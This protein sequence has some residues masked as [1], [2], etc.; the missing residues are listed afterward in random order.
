M[1][2]DETDTECTTTL[3]LLAVDMVQKANSGH[4]GMPLGA[5]DIAHVLWTRYLRINP[6]NPRWFN[7]DRFVLSAGHGS[8]LLYALLHLSGFPLSVE[9]L[10]TFRQ[11]G[12]KCP[13]HP[14]YDP[15]LGLGIE[16][17]TGPLGQGLANAVGL[18][19]AE[20]ILAAKLNKP[21]FDVV[22]HMTYVI[23][24]DG[25]LMEGVSHEAASLAGHLGL[26]RLIVLYD[27]NNVSIDGTLDI[28]LS[29]DALGRFAAYGWD[30]QRCD[31]HNLDA[32]DSAIARARSV[33]NKPHLIAC[34]TR[35]GLKSPVE[36]S[37]KSH[38]TP[39]GPEGVAKTRAAYG[40]SPTE[41]P[42]TVPAAAR[43]R[44]S[45]AVAHRGAGVDA[46]WRALVRKYAEEYPELG[47]LLLLLQDNKLPE[48]WR[49]SVPMFGAGTSPMATRV[50]SGKILESVFPAIPSLV[51][52]SADLTP[53]TNTRASSCVD[54]ARQKAGNYV[55][56]GVREHAMG[57]IM[58]G[59]ALHHLRP[60]GGTFLVFSDYMRP[61]IRMAAL[62]RIPT[63]FVFTHDSIGL[64]EDGPTHQPVEHL[65]A[66]RAIP[67]LRVIRPA[68]P[69]E[70]AAAWRIALERSDGPTAIVLSRQDLPLL[71]PPGGYGVERGA[72]V[73]GDSEQ[74]GPDV[75]V[76]ATGSELML[77]V[78]AQRI[79]A[80]EQI[81]ARVVSA[82]CIEFFESQPESYRKAV[83][84]ANVPRIGV[85]AGLT[86]VWQRFGCQRA[87]GLDHFG[88]SASAKV[89]YEHF[90]ITSQAIVA[91]AK[92]L[93]GK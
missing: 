78:E 10:Q 18:A 47:E 59:L 71:T 38:G 36:G 6:S 3:R 92:E 39:L 51:G 62:M 5:A 33:A 58:N 2:F 19:L 44:Y 25:D 35:I 76:I 45:E 55:H 11:L 63:I 50:A 52:G 56:Y 88:A 82:P 54:V 30:V 68:D 1:P 13:G 87:I 8:A 79:L 91:A 84:P 20:R 37:P 43:A 31:G 90:M 34:K 86:V 49:D 24:S 65:Y 12:S 61:P 53:S 66:L 29:D 42:F 7:R 60:Y 40:R 83:L 75:V 23:S 73:V 81:S 9:D 67:G 57:S 85:E 89:L 17:T 21:G 93:L 26:D 77:A 74:A 70:T 80:A 27:D 41:E 48:G 72:Y 46:G 14:E 22:D 4:P 32:L 28:Q 15:H 64:G 69:N 16:T